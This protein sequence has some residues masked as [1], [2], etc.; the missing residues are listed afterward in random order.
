M[1]FDPYLLRKRGCY[2]AP[3]I[4]K[5]PAPTPECKID[6]YT[7]YFRE[8]WNTL[9]QGPCNRKSLGDPYRCFPKQ[10]YP[11]DTNEICI[12]QNHDR[13]TSET[14]K[15]YQYPWSHNNIV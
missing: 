1:A 2:R 15:K 3:L 12:S 8:R 14:N 13:W 6:D 9:Q 11:L 5:Q 4:Y 10:K 7:W